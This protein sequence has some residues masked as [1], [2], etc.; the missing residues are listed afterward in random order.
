[1]VSVNDIKD[2]FVIKMGFLRGGK[3]YKQYID[4]NVKC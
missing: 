2:Y 4:Y 3:L 1:M